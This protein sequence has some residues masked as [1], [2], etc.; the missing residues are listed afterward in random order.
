MKLLV[1]KKCYQKKLRFG[2]RPNLTKS[3]SLAW[4]P[5]SDGKHELDKT[6]DS[7]VEYPDTRVAV[8]WRV[9]TAVL[10]TL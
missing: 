5:G 10:Y 3:N 2:S 7:C 8:Q 6:Q 1:S 9:Y 4:V